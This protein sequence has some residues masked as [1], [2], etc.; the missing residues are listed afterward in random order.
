MDKKI[1][2]LRKKID[3]LDKKII[4]T[5]E[6]RFKIVDKIRALKKKEEISIITP[7]REKEVKK[8]LKT[9]NK[10][11]PKIIDN[12]YKEIFAYSKRK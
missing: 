11:N 9:Q 8:K 7:Q 3:K 10:I 5:L 12:I 6:K 4:S 2:L 1:P